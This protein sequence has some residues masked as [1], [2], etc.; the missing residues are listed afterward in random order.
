MLYLDT[1]LLVT[2]LTNEPES[3]DAQEWL[4]AQR[5][6]ELVISDWV[7][8]EVASAM[9]QKQRA[10]DVDE[11]GR[12][13]A[14]QILARLRRESL[15]VLPVTREAFERAATLCQRAELLLRASDALHLAVAEGSRATVC[16]RDRRQAEAALAIGMS[17]QLLFAGGTRG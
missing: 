9:S 15:G 3:H 6:G 10:G 16:T 4:S 1:S 14:E 7:L 12:S 5:E 8:T 2:S 13:R 17:A 11:V